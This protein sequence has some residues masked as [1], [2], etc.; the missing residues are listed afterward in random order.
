M[1]SENRRHE[2]RVEIDGLEL[3]DEVLRRIDGAVRRAVL[4]E[5]ASVDLLKDGRSVDLLAEGL[6]ASSIGGTGVPRASGCV[7]RRNGDRPAGRC[8]GAGPVPPGG[9]AA[10]PEFHL[11]RGRGRDRRPR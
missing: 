3:S 6:T 7:R 1:P 8:A 11:P 2:F 4:H 10:V 9:G 5:I